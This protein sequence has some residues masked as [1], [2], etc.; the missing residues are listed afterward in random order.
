MGGGRPPRGRRPGPARPGRLTPRPQL[1][2]DQVRAFLEDR[3]GPVEG[4]TP[5]SGGFWSA[6]YSFLASGREL[7]VRFGSSREWVEADRAAAAFDGPDLPV[8]EVLDIGE[9]FGGAYAV[10]VR[11]YGR[12]LELVEPDQVDRAG[13]T[14]HRLLK[15]LFRVAG[16]AD[17]PVLWHAAVPPPQLTW[18]RWLTDSM[19]DEPARETHGWRPRLAAD[20][21]LDRLYRDCEAR[22]QELAESCPERRDLVHGDLLHQNVLVAPDAGRVT[23]VFSWKC[24]LR[25][26]FLYDT[27]WCTFWGAFHPGIAAADP[28]GRMVVDAEIGAEPDALADA[29]LR[30]H[31]YELHI[32]VIHLAWNAWTGDD[33]SL[34][35]VAAHLEMV[36]ERGPLPVP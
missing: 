9:A 33:H 11:R 1:T 36:R 34:R 18:R 16:H 21:Q 24:S 32:G 22:V 27:A 35:E 28:W 23:A 15:A 8:P 7:V 12:P 5:L 31:C 19:V 29:A 30:H 6:A 10:S 26:D 13:P 3:L 20:R 2:P 14:L 4:V 17:M 25:G